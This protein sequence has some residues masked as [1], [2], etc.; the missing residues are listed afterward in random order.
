ML[1]C[2][3]RLLAGPAG[4]PAAPLAEVLTLAQYHWPRHA[5][6]LAQ[7]RPLAR[8]VAALPWDMLQHAL[9]TPD[10]LEELLAWVEEDGLVLA[11]GD[12]KP[13]LGGGATAKGPAGDSPVNK[14]ARHVGAIVDEPA[15]VAAAL[16]SCLAAVSAP[17][18]APAALPQ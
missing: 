15:A 8:R 9:F 14:L 5:P 3:V 1:A 2:D 12:C 16:C 6:V 10:L 13:A 18:P 17:A 4:G 7:L 11:D